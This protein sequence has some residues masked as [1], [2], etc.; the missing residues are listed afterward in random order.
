MYSPLKYVRHVFTAAKEFVKMIDAFY[1][2]KNYVV[3]SGSSFYR[4]KT[5]ESDDPLKS[6]PEA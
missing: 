3:V 6:I 1:M 2:R 5:I 4:E